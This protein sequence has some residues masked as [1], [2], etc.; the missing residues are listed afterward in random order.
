MQSRWTERQL[1]EQF[2]YILL[3]STL[4]GMDKDDIQ[5]HM[6]QEYPHISGGHGNVKLVNKL[7][8]KVSTI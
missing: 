7:Y 3:N 6:Q 1:K 4:K 5:E 2:D 8:H